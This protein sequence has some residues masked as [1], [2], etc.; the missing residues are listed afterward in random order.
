MSPSSVLIIK[1]QWANL[2]LKGEKTWELRGCATKKRGIIGISPSGTSTL[3]GQVDL[4]D[5]V[6]IAE[7]QG[8]GTYKSL[9]PLPLDSFVKYHG[10]SNWS[11]IQYKSVYA[12]V[13][14]EPLR[15]SCAKPFDRP[16]GPVIWVRL[17]ERSKKNVKRT[18]KKSVKQQR[19]W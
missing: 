12:W 9:L 3:V 17:D 13:L 18:P 8:D 4:V 10:V 14:R 19:V 1:D 2:I 15:Y 16:Q 6:K 7:K 11:F 5:C